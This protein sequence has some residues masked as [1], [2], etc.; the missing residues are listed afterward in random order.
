MLPSLAITLTRT[1][2]DDPRNQLEFWLEEAA[3]AARGMCSEH[4]F[5]GALT[6]AATDRVWAAYP[7]N[8][9]NFVDVIA[10]GDAPQIRARPTWALPNALDAAASA[11]E[12]VIW[13]QA[14]DRN[15]AYN[16]AGTRL[17]AALLASIGEANKTHLQSVLPG[18]ALYALLPRQVIDAMVARHGIL[19][20]DD[21]NRLRLPL[22]SPLTS[23]ADLLTHQEKYLL[24]SQRLTRNGQ[25]ETPFKYFEMYLET[26]KGFPLVL[27]SMTPYYA[28]NPGIQTQNLGTLFPFLEGTLFTFLRSRRQ[29]Q[30]QPPHPAQRQPT[31]AQAC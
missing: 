25:G 6:L 20:S 19:T 3:T 23:L 22:S 12:V 8:V 9:T 15:H 10:N 2:A 11:A 17:S 18:I 7:G 21:V 14:T 1:L 30:R 24:A 16:V 4:D 27:H 31:H 5:S 29:T 28:A 13:R 26:L